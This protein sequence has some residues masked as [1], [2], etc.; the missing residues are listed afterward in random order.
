MSLFR[1][2]SKNSHVQCESWP[3]RIRIL[4]SP[5]A[6]TGSATVGESRGETHMSLVYLSKLPSTQLRS[7]SRSVHPFADVANVASSS[8]TT[9]A[10][11]PRRWAE[12]LVNVHGW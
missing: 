1:Q 9:P 3:S 5:L 2:K 12:P 8:P 7:N 11:Q 10:C 6:L 4:G